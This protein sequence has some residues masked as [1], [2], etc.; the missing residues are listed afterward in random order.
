MKKHF[1][2]LLATLLALT[3]FTSCKFDKTPKEMDY[4]GVYFQYPRA[5]SSETEELNE[6][7]YYITCEQ[8][9]G[10]DIV[11]LTVINDIDMEVE[12]Y[13]DIYFNTLE[14]KFNS[15][16]KKPM[17]ESTFAGYDC[18]QID[19]TGKLLRETVYGSVYGFYIDDK[20]IFIVT[21][22]DTERR[23]QNNF[24]LIKSSFEVKGSEVEDIEET[25]GETIEE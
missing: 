22:T 24:E 1:I 19:Y 8:K 23:L 25:I 9:A 3:L 6:G 15:L 20:L 11:T 2:L 13:F 17:T 10:S 4:G 12:E 7:A 16:S 14:G 5:W 21:Q 18:L